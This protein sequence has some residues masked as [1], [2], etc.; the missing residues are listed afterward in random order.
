ME[1]DGHIFNFK[2]AKPKQDLQT[3]KNVNKK[4]GRNNQSIG[5]GT[6]PTNASTRIARS[7]RERFGNEID[8]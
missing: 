4:R 2:L 7:P 5:G 3:V 8:S 6:V 1:I